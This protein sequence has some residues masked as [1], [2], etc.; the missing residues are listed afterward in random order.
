MKNFN[1]NS[2]YSIESLS[3]RCREI[4]ERENKQNRQDKLYGTKNRYN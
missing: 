4:L 1:S 2:Q 3:L